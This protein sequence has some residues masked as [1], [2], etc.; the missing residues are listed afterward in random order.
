MKA[1]IFAAG[2]G[3]RMGELT[4]NMPKPLLP[5]N[6]KP[7]IAYTLESLKKAGIKDV[8]INLAYLGK[9]IEQ[10]LG[11]GTEYGV[12]IKYSFEPYPLETAGAI[13]FAS[14]LLGGDPFLLTNAD[15]WTDF[16][17]HKLVE[18][19]LPE[20]VQGHLIMVDNP[21]HNVHGDFRL[22]DNGFLSLKENPNE[23]QA[24]TFSGISLI[25]P[26]LVLNYHNRQ[27]KFPLVDV[28][29]D[30]IEKAELTGECYRGE[31]LD[32]GTPERLFSIQK[33]Q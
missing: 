28:F 33:R 12:N 2:R 11:E 32:I 10:A 23:N 9:Q 3:E 18:K 17:Y 8:V 26:S 15:V 21:G 14:Q 1:M 19:K 29:K 5:V 7:L 24:L 16:P 30:A 13:V 31:W 4:N 6:G 20:S 25:N 22:A 27:E